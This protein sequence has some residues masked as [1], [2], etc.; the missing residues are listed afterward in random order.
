VLLSIV[1]LMA[2]ANVFTTQV[3]AAFGMGSGG[4]KLRDVGAIDS[5]TTRSDR[6]VADAPHTS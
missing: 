3:E 4:P 6:A 2:C 5:A 1:P